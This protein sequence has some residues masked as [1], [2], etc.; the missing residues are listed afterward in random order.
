ME[1]RTE[2]PIRASRRTSGRPA[3]EV[4]CE[5]A[6]G[7]NEPPAVGGSGSGGSGLWAAGRPRPSDGQWAQA[8]G[9]PES[10]DVRNDE[11]QPQPE[12]ALGL[13]T[14]KPAPMSVST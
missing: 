10:S 3:G 7:I 8:R 13:A 12:T 5:S 4:M 2:R 1:G 11:P 6:P 9:E 14:V